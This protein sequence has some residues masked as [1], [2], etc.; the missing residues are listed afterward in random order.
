[1]FFLFVCSTLIHMNIEIFCVYMSIYVYYHMKYEWKNEKWK[2]VVSHQEASISFPHNKMAAFYF[3]QA[4]HHL[5]V[6]KWDEKTKEGYKTTNTNKAFSHS[7]FIDPFSSIRCFTLDVWEKRRSQ[8]YCRL[9]PGIIASL[10]N[11][12]YMNSLRVIRITYKSTYVWMK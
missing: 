12:M 7:Y 11:F 4:L 1:M 2:V 5:C 9:C 3:S 8:Y 6:S 10:Y